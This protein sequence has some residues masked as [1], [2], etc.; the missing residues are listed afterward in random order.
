MG[1]P[2]TLAGIL[3]VLITGAVNW[4]RHVGTSMSIVQWP[5]HVK[6][7]ALASSSFHPPALMFC[8]CLLPRCLSLG[9]R[10]VN[11][12]NSPTAQHLLMLGTLTS[13]EPCP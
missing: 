2:P 6:K 1:G 12:D 13:Y 9:G 11:L 5:C 10:E 4:A 3:T 7:S 8:M